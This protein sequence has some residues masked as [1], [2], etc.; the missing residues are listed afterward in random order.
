VDNA[1]GVIAVPGLQITVRPK[2]P[3]SHLTFMFGKVGV[4]PRLDEQRT[5]LDPDTKLIDL[6]ARWFLS[7][8]ESLVRLGLARD[9]Q[10]VRSEE[11]TV[12]GR[13]DL[14]P[15]A[16]RYYSG[17]LAFPCEYEELTYDTPLNRVVRG[18]V[19]TLVGSSLF[20][21]EIRRRAIRLEA[22]LEDAS[23][24]RPDDLRVTLNRRT[25]YYRD[26]VLLARAVIRNVGRSP[27]AGGEF[28]WT[29]LIRTPEAVEEAL[30]LWLAEKLSNAFIRK[31]GQQLSGT[32][33]TLTPD[34]V[35]GAPTAVGDIKYKLSSGDWNRADFYQL[36]AFAT[37]FRVKRGL[38]VQFRRPGVR[39]CPDLA[40]G[41]VRVTE[42]AWPAD[43]LLPPEAAAAQFLD[44]V[45]R[46]VAA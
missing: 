36:I 28:G 17:N 42:C 40:V 35:F 19:R 25:A 22:R 4:W 24:L 38:L 44:E 5:K 20:S 18:A 11:R 9:Y 45:G 2:I 10:V 27:L 46:W 33:L 32:R 39:T 1:V 37:G 30:R 16:R 41:D 12:R 6:I 15:T 14:L 23:N 26:S 3:L 8:T 29:F 21:E 13:L 7:A 43:P 31:E 34:L